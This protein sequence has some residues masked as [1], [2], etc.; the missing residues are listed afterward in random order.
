MIRAAF[1]KILGF[2]MTNDTFAQACLTPLLGGLGLR[3]VQ[4]HSDLAFAALA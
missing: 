4:E 2:P 1:E 3:K